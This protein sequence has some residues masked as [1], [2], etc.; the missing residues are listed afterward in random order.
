MDTN[1]NFLNISGWG[2]PL[3]LRTGAGQLLG[4]FASRSQ[5][6]EVLGLS[7]N[8]SKALP[9]G[10]EIYAYT[11]SYRKLPASGSN[12]PAE[13]GPMIGIVE[14]ASL[15]DTEGVT[16][17]G[18][19]VF[20]KLATGEDNEEYVDRFKECIMQLPVKSREEY[21][22]EKRR[23][24]G[25]GLK[26]ILCAVVGCEKKGNKGCLCAGQFLAPRRATSRHE[27][28]TPLDRGP[29]SLPSRDP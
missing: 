9:D 1:A 22:Q 20:P 18:R 21:S 26:G 4:G 29:D 25:K 19:S 17:L 16:E 27:I 15:G 28:S 8:Q 2:N 11:P 3:V 23:R 24:S 5:L 13:L 10:R 6:A 12:Q 7:I 14:D